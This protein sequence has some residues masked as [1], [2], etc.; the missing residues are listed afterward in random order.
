MMYGKQL[1]SSITVDDPEKLRQ[2]I[3]RNLEYQTGPKL[4]LKKGDFSNLKQN[5]RLMHQF[6]S[7]EVNAPVELKKSIRLMK[8][9]DANM[10]ALKRSLSTQILDP[11]SRKSQI[12]I[13]A[14]MSKKIIDF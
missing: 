12:R 11:N 5:S 13:K 2:S 6:Y 1:Y 7:E 8:K 10:K 3:L 9:S 4:L 14:Q